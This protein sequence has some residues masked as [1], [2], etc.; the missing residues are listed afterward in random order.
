MLYD[1]VASERERESD[2]L[3]VITFFLSVMVASLAVRISR[4]PLNVVD[5]VDVV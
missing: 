4:P 1:V 2:E 3:P 5:V